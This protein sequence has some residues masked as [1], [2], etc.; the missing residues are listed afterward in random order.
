MMLFIGVENKLREANHPGYFR[1]YETHEFRNSKRLGLAVM[2]LRDDDEFLLR[3]IAEEFE[4]QRG[5]FLHHIYW[6]DFESVE[7]RLTAQG[8]RTN[9]NELE[10]D[11]CTVM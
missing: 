9:P 1:V 2:A 3:T 4:E 6:E 10:L 8:Q 11:G 5:G 7:D